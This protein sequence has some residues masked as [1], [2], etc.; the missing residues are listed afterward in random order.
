MWTYNV[1]DLAVSTKDQIRFL[2][3]DTQSADPQLQDEEV[4]FAASQ[5]SNIWGAAAICCFSLATYFAR[6][7]DTTTG[8]LRTLWSSLSRSY[9]LRASQYETTATIRSGALPY[10][11]GIS[12]QDK[13]NQEND[14]DRVPPQF[15]IGMDDNSIPVPEAGNEPAP[16]TSTGPAVF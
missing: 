4:L 14:T 5:R 13:I 1:S 2:V 8:E 3:G 6:K 16:L 15:N 11:G 9:A 7:A 10:A 12:I